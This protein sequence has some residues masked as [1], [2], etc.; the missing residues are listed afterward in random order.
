MKVVENSPQNARNAPFLK[1]FLGGACLQTPL[2]KALANPAYAHELRLR[3]LFENPPWQTDRLCVV[4]YICLC[5]TK[6]F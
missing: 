5:I 3:N 2:A 6:S 4:R 1:I